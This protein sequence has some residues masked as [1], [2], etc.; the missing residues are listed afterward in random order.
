MMQPNRVITELYEHGTGKFF[1]FRTSVETFLFKT[2]FVD[3]TLFIM[4]RSGAFS[5][6]ATATMTV[7]V[8]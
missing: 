1:A 2:T 3:V 4:F 7:P 8:N 5:T 6:F